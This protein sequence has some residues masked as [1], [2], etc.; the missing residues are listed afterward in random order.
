MPQI[1][2]N[3]FVRW[4]LVAVGVAAIGYTVNY[5]LKWKNIPAVIGRITP[6]GVGIVY[7]RPDGSSTGYIFAQSELPSGYKEAH[8]SG[9]TVT[10]CYRSDGNLTALAS[11]VWTRDGLGFGVGAL[12]IFLGL[13]V[14]RNRPA[15][16]ISS[17]P[18]PVP[19][20]SSPTVA[21]PPPSSPPPAKS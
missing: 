5:S 12:V 21:P 2:V 17:A 8:K 1:A 19:E 13:F 10:I 3:R 14:F 4:T 16:P 9:D 11:A 6:Q 18:P 20:T 7:T 15:A